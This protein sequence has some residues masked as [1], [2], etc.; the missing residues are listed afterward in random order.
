M[1]AVAEEFVVGLYLEK[2]VRDC[3]R[4][5]SITRSL[6]DEEFGGSSGLNR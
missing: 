5:L 6:S 4:L 1:K 2:R 3:G